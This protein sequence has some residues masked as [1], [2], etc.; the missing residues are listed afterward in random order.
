MILSDELNHASI[1]DAVRLAR[2]ARKKAVYKH[3]DLDDLRA[4]LEALEP[5][6]RPIVITDGVF[7]MEGDLARL[8]E[9]VELV[10][11]HAATL[12]RRR[13]TRHGRPWGKRVAASPST[14]ACWARST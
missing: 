3:W 10:R 9:L 6:Q 5:G 2:P 8:P 4:Q 1:I 11:E 14:S 13:P 7:S 12:D